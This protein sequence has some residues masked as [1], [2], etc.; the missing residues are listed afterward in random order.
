MR[1]NENHNISEEL[2]YAMWQID[3]VFVTFC[4]SKNI[5]VEMIKVSYS[6]F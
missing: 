3:E 6:S 1:K 5:L 4:I 2:S